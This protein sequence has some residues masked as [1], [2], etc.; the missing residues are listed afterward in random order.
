MKL[1]LPLLL[2][3]SRST[4]VLWAI[5]ATV[6][7]ISCTGCLSGSS[8]EVEL[9]DVSGAVTLNGKPIEHLE[10]LFQ[11]STEAAASRG[12][13]D[14]EGKFQLYYPPEHPGAVLGKHRVSFDLKDADQNPD[15][16]PAKYR[17]GAA[18]IE[19]EVKPDAPNEFAFDLSKQKK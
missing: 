12:L 17:S 18:G 2:T 6:A 1:Q 10:V 3:K 7:I 8:P 19:V 5:F 13:T 11:P 4:Y 15:I 14:A 9:A 16:V